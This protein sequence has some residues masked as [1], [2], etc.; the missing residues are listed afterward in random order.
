M[1]ISYSNSEEY[2]MKPAVLPSSLHPWHSAPG[3]REDDGGSPFSP[4]ECCSNNFTGLSPQ[5]SMSLPPHHSSLFQ[6]YMLSKLLGWPEEPGLGWP[7]EQRWVEAGCAPHSEWWRR[8]FLGTTPFDRMY[9]RQRP[10][11]P[12]PCTW[13]S[14][15][16]DI[17]E[18]PQL[19]V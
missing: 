2:L 14:V 13:E 16:A 19:R 6:A 7:E 3:L 1:T 5:R 9:Q 10:W 4:R 17:F 11:V 18:N 15:S 8:Q 12:W